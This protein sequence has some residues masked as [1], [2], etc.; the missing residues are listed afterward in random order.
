[1]GPLLFCALSLA[2][3]VRPAAAREPETVTL[4]FVGDMM[5]GRQVE[6]VMRHEHD[7]GFP[8]RLLRDRL[9]AADLTFGN[10]ECVAARS[11]TKRTE[12]EFRTDPQAL[13]GLAD[14][15]FDVVSIAN[16]HTT[17]WGPDALAETLRELER[18][19][20]A[21]V[22]LDSGGIQAPV[23]L[24]AGG[25]R[26]GFLAFSHYAGGDAAAHDRVR[27]ALIGGKALIGAVQAARPTVDYLVV[28]LHTGKQFE[29]RATRAQQE[30]A[31]AA[32]E[33]GADLVVGHHPHVPQEIEKH[34]RGFIA[35]SLGDFVFDHPEVS[36]EGAIL[37]VTLAGTEPTRIVY[38]RTRMNARFQ[39]EAVGEERFEGAALRG[40]DGV[41]D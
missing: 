24:R 29:K 40:P 17:D 36:Q 23:V 35:Y 33:A 21:P 16:T 27:I 4:L 31:R 13:D 6:A 34:G 19:K 3:S 5:L 32:I 2:L 14:A 9:R 10:L 22:G 38:T 12:Y 28:S 25:L 30:I 8:L 41:L 37:A 7:W 11:G 39:P 20:I 1:M 18:R 26:V 15:G